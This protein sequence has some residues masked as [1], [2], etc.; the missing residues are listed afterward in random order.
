M[1]L[2][3]VC[4]KHAQPLFILPSLEE[5]FPLKGNLGLGA[6]CW[7]YVHMCVPACVYVHTHFL[8]IYVASLAQQILFYPVRAQPTHQFLACVCGRRK[9]GKQMFLE[10]LQRT[11]HYRG[12]LKYFSLWAMF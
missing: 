4:N 11:S 8:D 1:K 12:E 3:S 7:S 6:S 9:L 10:E 2:S 5:P